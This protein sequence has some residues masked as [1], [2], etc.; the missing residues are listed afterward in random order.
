M[1]TAT[2]DL[3]GKEYATVPQR[4]K[5][6]REANPR[7]LIETKPSFN[8]DGTVVFSA[9]IVKDKA[10]ENSAEA[11]GHSWGKISGEKA[12][13]K[14]ETIST[15][16]ALSLLGYLSNGEIASGEEMEEY[17]SYR[18]GLKAEA[19]NEAIIKLDGA[20]TL[21]ELKSTFVSLGTV[22]SE[23]EVIKAKDKRKAELK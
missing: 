21:E 2:I 12:F 5:E 10:D 23:A 7:A 19:I 17:E 16:R 8:E 4:L 1:K 11:T 14:L 22:M 20:K 6:F 15:G 13:E 3:K 18:D 9:R